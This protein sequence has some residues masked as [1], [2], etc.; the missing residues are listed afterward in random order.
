ME[1]CEALDHQPGPRL[2]Q[3][4]KARDRVTEQSARNPDWVLGFQDECW[5]S[6]LA[7]PDVF[8]WATDDPLRLIP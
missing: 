8:A 4:K 7:Q 2:R 3:E 1:A 5:W 6:R